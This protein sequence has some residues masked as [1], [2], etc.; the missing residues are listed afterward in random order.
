ML[1]I[2]NL[3]VVM[4]LKQHWW[5]TSWRLV[6]GIF[7]AWWER[8]LEVWFYCHLLKYLP[9]TQFKQCSEC[10]GWVNI[11]MNQTLCLHNLEKF[12][13][14]QD[15]VCEQQQHHPELW[16]QCWVFIITVFN[17]VQGNKRDSNNNWSCPLS[18]YEFQNSSITN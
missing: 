4:T 16:Y 1:T 18:G 11:I 13:S 7:I 15:E 2:N 6:T 9:Y 12:L 5:D 17:S 10:R 14:F 3:M 8:N